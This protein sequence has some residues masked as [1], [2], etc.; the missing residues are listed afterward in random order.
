MQEITL[1]CCFFFFFLIWENSGLLGER[2]TPEPKQSRLT[3]MCCFLFSDVFFVKGRR[4]SRCLIS[5]FL[6]LFTSNCGYWNAQLSLLRIYIKIRSLRRTTPADMAKS[7]N[8][9]CGFGSVTWSNSGQLLQTAQ[10]HITL[11][12]SILTENLERLIVC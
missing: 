9:Y 4:N 3:L 10:G 1:Q 8:S 5:S 11:R 6:Q 7:V 12:C 2:G